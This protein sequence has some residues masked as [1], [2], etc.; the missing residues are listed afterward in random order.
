MK[1]IAHFVSNNPVKIFVVI[2]LLMIPA[3]ISAIFTPINYD[4][5]T[6]LPGNVE[7]VR[8]QLIMQK[9]YNSADTAFVLLNT[10]DSSEVLKIK[11]DL[12][13]ID[14]VQK[15]MWISDLVDPSI[16]DFMIPK[17]ILSVYKKGNN[18]ML[19]ISFSETSA[20][21]R[22]QKAVEN[23]S[24][25]LNPSVPFTGF[26]V[27][28]YQLR[29]LIEKQKIQSI[30]FAVIVSAIVIAIATGSLV[31]PLVLLAAIGSGIIFNMGTNFLAGSISYLTAAV[32]AVIQLGVTFDFSIYVI[33]RYKEEFRI[34]RD[35][36]VAM[37]IALERSFHAIFP[38]AMVTIAGFMA[39]AVMKIKIGMDMGIV[40]S[41][42][43]LW[44]LVM[45]L[46]YL[47][48]MVLIFNRFIRIR[49]VNKLHIANEKFVGV[50]VKHRYTLFVIFLIL[51]VPAV[52]G[53][54]HVNLSYSIEDMMPQDLKAIVAVGDISKTMGSVE[55][56]NVIFDKNT[57][58]WQIK[59]AIN[60]LK[61]NKAVEQTIS[62]YDNVDLS[63]PDSFIPENVKATFNRG[64]YKSAMLRLSVKPGTI[65]GNQAVDEIRATIKTAGINDAIVTGLCATSK[66]LTSLSE[67]DIKLVDMLSLISI[68]IIIAIAFKSISIPIIMILNVQLAILINL[69]IPYFMG[70]SVPFI[71][72]TA[73]SAIQLGTTVNYSIFLMARYK[74]ERHQ[75]E[76]RQAIIKTVSGSLPSIFMSALSL[77]A[78]TLSLVFVS[79][80]GT[81]QA[82]AG[83]IGRGAVISMA[84]IVLFMP[85]I[86]MV[87]DRFIVYTSLGWRKSSVLDNSDK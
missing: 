78:A 57:P 62:L 29:Q 37:A 64:D 87:L 61:K 54:R 65:E 15:V 45:S 39:L 63:I 5:F 35:E 30:T 8:G 53:Q 1:R 11:N 56:A 4:I 41:K 52:W 42:G 76:K 23:I 66:D 28:I 68:F 77:L 51:F 40:M 67:K 21:E 31:T 43:V 26:P 84:V 75:H 47:P 50:L 70:N 72:F 85:P 58:D 34:H 12:A 7:S 16:P 9:V 59:K 13:A 14:G 32:A 79:N 49:E 33:N 36:K 60:E 74:E 27:F 55:M 86:I 17:E 44:G 73:I 2:T 80:V 3:A 82:L 20:M 18:S 81:I 48:A 10:A 69:C 38:A 24:A 6:Y 46:V 71:T 19:H 25:Y 22:T 83:M